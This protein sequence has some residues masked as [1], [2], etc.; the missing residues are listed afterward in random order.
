MENFDIT[1]HKPAF[2][3][4]REVAAELEEYERRVSD[5]QDLEDGLLAVE[6]DEVKARV[7]AALVADSNARI[8]AAFGLSAP[9]PNFSKLPVETALSD[10]GFPE[11]RWSP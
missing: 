10:P 7:L 6:H 8:A 9:A 2:A 1:F 4:K 5:P 11:P 3:L